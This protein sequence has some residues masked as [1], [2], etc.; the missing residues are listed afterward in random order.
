M[1]MAEVVAQSSLR[2]WPATVATVPGPPELVFTN[3]AGRPLRRN[4]AGSVWHRAV[5]QAALSGWATFHELR[6]FSASL[7]IARGCSVKAVQK[8][9][10]HQS[11][12]ETF[13]TSLAG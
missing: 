1:P 9:L 12:M 11:P 5:T 8:R 10:G 7:L 6:H 3:P 13:D 4:T 2:T